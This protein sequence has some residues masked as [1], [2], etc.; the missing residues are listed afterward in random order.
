MKTKKIKKSSPQFGTK[1]GR[2][3]LDLFG[4]T[5]P[6][7]SDQPALKSQWTLNLDGGTLNFVGRMLTLDGGALPPHPP[8][9]L[10]SALDSKA[11]G[12][13]LEDV[14]GLEDTF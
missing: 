1:F 3:L 2:N 12:G 10:S 9:N 4:L 7:S 6:F 8:Y 13:V 5:G 14:L 11:R